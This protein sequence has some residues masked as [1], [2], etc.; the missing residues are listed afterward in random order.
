[1]NVLVCSLLSCGAA[2]SFWV[3]LVVGWP[4]WCL[5]GFQAVIDLTGVS[6][7]SDRCRAT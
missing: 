4:V 2:A 1:V 6:H 5:G 7:R 3:S